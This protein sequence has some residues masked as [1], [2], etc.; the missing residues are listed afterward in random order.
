MITFTIE[1]P[2]SLSTQERFR[3]QVKPFE[4]SAEALPRRGDFLE[5]EGESY[6]V[7]TVQFSPDQDGRC[8]I[9]VF[10]K[11]SDAASSQA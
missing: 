2:E 6:E 9:V 3:E 10:L 1:L 5:I 4:F 8:S 11:D 7:S